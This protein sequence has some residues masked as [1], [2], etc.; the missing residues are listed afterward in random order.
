MDFEIAASAKNFLTPEQNKMFVFSYTLI[1]AFHPKLNLNRVIVQRSFGHSLLK[2]ATVD[3]LTKDQ[4]KFVDQDLINQLTNCAIN[5]SER[6]CKNAVRQIFA[7]EL[8]FA[9]NCFL[10]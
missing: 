2:L 3:Y 10:K 1:F 9:S 8:K 5:V 7:V 6:Q 4:L